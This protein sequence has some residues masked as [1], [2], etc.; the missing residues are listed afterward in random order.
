MNSRY[1]Q[2]IK[3]S[4][5]GV[6]GQE[7]LS[8]A[9]V[10]CVGM[11]GLGSALS[12][13]LAGAGV[14]TLGLVDDDCVDLSNLQR[15]TLYR[16]RQLGQ[17]KAFAAAAELN[18]L[19]PEIQIKVYSERLSQQNLNTM[20][21]DYDVIADGSDNFQTRYLLHDACFTLG[22]PYVYASA[23]AYEGYCSL[24]HG[25]QAPCLR[26]IFPNPSTG[27]SCSDEGV[28][29]VLPGILGLIQAS[30]VIKWIVGLGE[31]LAGRL[32]RVDVKTMRFKELTLTKDPS[33]P[34]CS[35]RSGITALFDPSH[36]ALHFEELA[37][38]IK[39]HN[40]LLIDVRNPEEHAAINIG[41]RL[42]PLHELPSRL[43]E[44]EKQQTIVLYC[45]AGPRSIKALQLLQEAGFSSLRYLKGGVSEL[46]QQQILQCEPQV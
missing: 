34:L 12:A 39:E 24:F 31:T 45:K 15:Q 1:A 38:F 13:Y 10:L 28:L 30:E 22:K 16:S 27:S 42:L 26:C 11:G 36:F 14:G 37:T 46:S 35:Q 6:S 21:A 2:Q 19:N 8:N 3:L 5:F 17:N 32:L 43:D 4:E 41:G 33:C 23:S 44:L 20:L 9:R 25:Q 7:K 29:G 40:A 18:A